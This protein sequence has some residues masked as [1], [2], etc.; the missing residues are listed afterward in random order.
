MC[1][2][3]TN[4]T[5]KVAWA[6]GLLLGGWFL[7]GP[8]VG[9]Q[10]ID[11]LHLTARDLTPIASFTDARA[12]GAAPDDRL[13]VAD[14][15]RDVVVALDTLGRRLLSMG[16]TGTRSGEFDTPADVDPTNGLVL[17]VADAG[18]GRIQRFSQEGQLI[19]TLPVGRRDPAGGERGRQPTYDMSEDGTDIRSTGRPVAVVS[20]STDETLAIDAAANVVRTW[21][22]QRR[23][24]PD[25]GGFGERSG[26]L[27]EPVALALD[28]QDR[29]YVADRGHAG[30]L[31]YDRFGTYVG[32]LPLPSLPEVQSLMTHRGRLWVVSPRQF[33][34]VDV[35]SRHLVQLGHVTL[36]EHI[37]DLAFQNGTLYVLTPTRLLR[38][39]RIRCAR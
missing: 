30:V 39:V 17:L 6:L 24:G 15:G 10:A 5:V 20:S 28:A 38:C 22:A 34:V 7:I 12:L 1:D 19:E 4:P 13:F 37:V 9:A 36:S 3:H 18:N 35:R 27:R 33:H 14:A 8:P 29:V 2:R 32:A 26:A 16:E 21:D 25:L 31:A 23:L 11:T